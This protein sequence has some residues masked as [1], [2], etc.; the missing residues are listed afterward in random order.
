M[1][2]IVDRMDYLICRGYWEMYGGNLIF[3]INNNG[4]CVFV[5]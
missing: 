1:G 3:V 5:R 2:I 4:I